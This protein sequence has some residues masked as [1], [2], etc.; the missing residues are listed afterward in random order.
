MAARTPKAR[1]LRRARGRAA[2]KLARD[3]ERLAQLEPGGAADRPID[4]ASP[5]Q[6]D[7][8]AE[9][10]PCPLCEGPLRLREHAAV[11]VDG[12]RLRAAHVACTA[13]GI[14]R[15]MYFRLSEPS[16]H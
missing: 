10:R 14:R 8:I 2:E 13:C 16:L 12:V 5:A 15:Q 3:R 6:V 11:T 1:T 7:V 9:A 4:V